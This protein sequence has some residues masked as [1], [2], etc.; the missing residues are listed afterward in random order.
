MSKSLNTSPIHRAN[1]HLVLDSIRNETGIDV[2]NRLLGSAGKKDLSGDID[3][4]L[5]DGESTVVQMAL[6]RLGYA[7]QT[8]GRTL[9]AKWPYQ[10][11]GSVE[12]Y[13]QVDFMSSNSVDGAKLFY[14]APVWSRYSGEMR[15]ILAMI[16]FPL[17]ER[18]VIKRHGWVDTE[19]DQIEVYD[20]WKFTPLDGLLRVRRSKVPRKDGNGFLKKKSD[21][22]IESPITNMDYIAGKFHIN[23]D[24]F[25]SIFWGVYHHYPE[26]LQ[27][28]FERLMYRSEVTAVPYEFLW[29]ND[30]AGKIGTL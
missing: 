23:V 15:T 27:E 26:I 8:T 30:E 17:I 14:H 16:V 18:K 1:I 3:I 20:M 19:V 29:L 7:N 21:E 11:V 6:D 24:S 25:E 13:V 22:V 12:S 2:S 28:T 9:S 5:V 10:P 4:V